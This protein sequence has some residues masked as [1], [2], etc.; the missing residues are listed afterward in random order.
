ME[1]TTVTITS[2][3]KVERE[4]A[5]TGEKFESVYVTTDDGQLFSC[6]MANVPN[7]D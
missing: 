2:V 3:K 1:K 6:I 5:K 4:N 7:L